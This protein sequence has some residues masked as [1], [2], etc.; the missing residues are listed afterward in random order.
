MAC[1]A[2]AVGNYGR[3][4]ESGESWGAIPWPCESGGS[5]VVVLCVYKTFGIFECRFCSS[6]KADASHLG[7]RAEVKLKVDTA[8]KQGKG[9]WIRGGGLGAP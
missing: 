5:S 7:C 1:E 9:F 2:G 3:A 4:C 8:D 6:V